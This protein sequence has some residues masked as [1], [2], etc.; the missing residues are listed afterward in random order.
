MA[1]R[2]S[3]FIKNA[4]DM[5]GIGDTYSTSLPGE[6]GA[7][8]FSVL[9]DLLRSLNTDSKFPTDI[10]EFKANPPQDSF[11]GNFK[12]QADESHINLGFTPVSTPLRVQFNA[13]EFY[14]VPIEQLYGVPAQR[15]LY[16]CTTSWE[17]DTECVKIRMMLPVGETSF[18]WK[19]PLAVPEYITDVVKLPQNVISYLKLLLA[20]RL[21]IHY[22]IEQAQTLAKAERDEYARLT[23]HNSTIPGLQLMETGRSSNLYSVY[24]GGY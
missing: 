10:E 3:E 13:N 7:Y 4:V 9:R 18:L 21:G 8:A 14:Q 20:T 5:T 17:D 24:D 11:W 22:G 15:W 16:G 23:E 2:Y 6:I 19:V 1:I 12:D